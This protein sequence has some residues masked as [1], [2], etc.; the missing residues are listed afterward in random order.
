MDADGLHLHIDYVASSGVVSS[1]EQ[2]AALQ[3][4]LV[5]LKNQQ[6]FSKIKFWGKILGIK[7]DYFLVQGVGKDDLKERKT[8]YRYNAA[9]RQDCNTLFVPLRYKYGDVTNRGGYK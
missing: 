5:I 7:S 1:V 6:K 4:S 3:S 9:D 8:L 2:K